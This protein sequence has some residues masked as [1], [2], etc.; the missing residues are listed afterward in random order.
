MADFSDALGTSNLPVLDPSLLPPDLAAAAAAPSPG[1]AAAVPAAA[2]PSPMLRLSVPVTPPASPALPTAAPPALASNPPAQG[3]GI[4]FNQIIG[5]MLRPQQTG[6][7]NVPSFM[8]ALGAGLS[9]A[10]QNWN[11]PA[12]AAFASGAGAA[13]QGGQQSSNQLQDARLKALHAAIAAWKVGDLAAYHQ[14]LVQF[15]AAS[16][17]P[18]G[19]PANPSP[20]APAAV[21]PSSAPA[22]A[23]TALSAPAAL[24]RSAAPP[25]VIAQARDAIARGA[26][27]DAVMA[28]L[29][30]YGI[31]PSGL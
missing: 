12:A 5:G 17:P 14:A 18:S 7:F 27:R 28:R 13:I 26:P 21:P 24:A 10:G 22:A 30:E 23:A 31:D 16:A 6:G 9:S 20:A 25:D 19:A 2:A 11:K 8:S 4:D 15:R 3:R 1:L 29:R